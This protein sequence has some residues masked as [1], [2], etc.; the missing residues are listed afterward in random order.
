MT[1]RFSAKCNFSTKIH[2]ESQARCQPFPIGTKAPFHKVHLLHCTC[3]S[4]QNGLASL[5][6]QA[7]TKD[8]QDWMHARTGIE[9]RLGRQELAHTI[10]S[11]NNGFILK[12]HWIS[13]LFQLHLSVQSQICNHITPYLFPF[14]ISFLPAD[15]IRCCERS[16]CK[17]TKVGPLF[18]V[19]YWTG[20]NLAAERGLVTK[21]LPKALGLRAQP[22]HGIWHTLYTDRSFRQRFYPT[23]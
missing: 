19:L 6:T 21:N 12:Q 23:I 2:P 1:I 16:C 5:N 17:I 9:T 15:L 4:T 8:W 14:P 7:G 3:R 22:R 13:S 10:K 11:V 18:A 20:R